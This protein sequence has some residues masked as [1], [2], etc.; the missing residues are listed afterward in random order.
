[1]EER[2]PP[3]D[4]GP[5]PGARGASIASRVIDMTDFRAAR[6]FRA[7]GLVESYWEALRAGRPAPARGELDPR[8]MEDALEYAFILERD[9]P[10]TGRLRIAGRHL[11]D[12]AGDEMRGAPLSLLFRLESR[13]ALSAV[14][15]ETCDG[16]AVATATLTAPASF[17]RPA[18]EG[19]LL[20]LPLAD[21]AG[22]L[23]RVLGCLETDGT[24]GRAPRQLAIVE[25][26]S[27]PI[28]TSAGEAQP[29]PAPGFAEPGQPFAGPRPGRRPHLRLVQ[30]G[31][32]G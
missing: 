5:P 19:R 8:G 20:L 12:L 10:R 30:P 26:R 9:A 14:L 28:R 17:E 13:A 21:A 29:T 16:P 32:D 4:R 25:T 31:R 2:E 18:L 3:G 6:R 22:C 11:C 24:L 15:A 23:T 27:R 1:M 7:P